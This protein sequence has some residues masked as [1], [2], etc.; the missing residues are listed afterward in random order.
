MGGVDDW[1]VFSDR[2]KFDDST[3]IS[4]DEI[5]P[6]G[7]SCIE[8]ADVVVDRVDV[9]RDFSAEECLVTRIRDYAS[10][11]E[12]FGVGDIRPDTRIC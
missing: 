7:L 9:E 8:R 2:P 10:F 11:G 5:D 6:R 4:P 1:L 3:P 12:R